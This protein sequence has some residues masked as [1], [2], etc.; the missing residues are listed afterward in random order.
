MGKL[1]RDL[2]IGFFSTLLAIIL[3]QTGIIEAWVKSFPS[4]FLITS[5]LITSVLITSFFAGI[6]YSSFFTSTIAVAVF[7]VLGVD[8]FNPLVVA[9][10]GGIGSLC[11]DLLI[12]KFVKTDV[13]ADL[14]FVD[15]KLTG[16]F[17]SR[18][19]QR[20]PFHFLT[21]ILGL[22]VIASPLPDE[23]G[24]SLLAASKLNVRNFI[25]LSYV[26][27]TIGIFLIVLLG[28]AF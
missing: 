14:R 1:V 19:A 7:I 16:G 10:L 15:K 20:K 18:L 13:A 23:L 27:N 3:V 8:G 21:F 25:I 4:S 12:F 5:V 22:I 17:F 6:L 24:V 9:V 26:L 11:T 2:A 28:R